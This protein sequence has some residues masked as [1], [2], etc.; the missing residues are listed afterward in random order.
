MIILGKNYHVFNNHIVIKP[1]A[2]IENSQII[3][4]DK[5]VRAEIFPN[6]GRIHTPTYHQN[7]TTGNFMI[8]ELEP[9]RTYEKNDESSHYYMVKQTRV[10]I[11]IFE[12]L[13]L[14]ESFE[15]DENK[16]VEKIRFGIPSKVETLSEIILQTTDNYLLGPFKT[17]YDSEGRILKIINNFE[18]DK[19][20]LP[21][22][23]NFRDQ[24]TIA[25]YY[26]Y[27][28][29]IQRNFTLE[30][31]E[32][33]N[34]IS[35]LDIA[36]EEYIV[37][38]A[39]RALRGQQEFGDITRRVSQGINE[40]LKHTT[41]SEEFNT[42]RLKKTVKLL[43]EI[44]PTDESNNYQKYSREL[45][46]LPSIN[47]IIEENTKKKFKLEYERFL[48]ENND[49]TEKNR[50]L[51]VKFSSLSSE[52]KIHQKQL[53]Q[54]QQ[55]IEKYNQ[56]MSSKKES[57]EK[58]ILEH[59]FQKLLINNLSSQQSHELPYMSTRESFEP[60]EGYENL[61]EIKKIFKHNLLQYEERDSQG[62]IFDYCLIA[63]KFNQPLMIAG[64]S[65]LK[66]AHI[67]QKTFAASETQTIIPDN[68][69]FNL[70]ALNDI[71]NEQKS[72]LNFTVIHNIQSSP[73]SLNLSGFFNA[74]E[75]R[76]TNNKIIFT[77]DS[78]DE[79]QFILEQL[80]KY[81]ILDIKHRAFI[82]SPFN[83]NEELK[84]GQIDSNIL[85]TYDQPVLNFQESLE[86]LL[87]EILGENYIEKEDEIE[88][89]FKN[90]YKR[91]TYINQFLGKAKKTLSYFPFL[92]KNLKED[93]YE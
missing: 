47:K 4:L 50:L 92:E 34:I 37:R 62:V 9:T 26:D 2:Q 64:E 66:L 41:F 23:D 54:V 61:D 20:I 36:K 19:Y 80:K 63:L 67:I 33:E 30:Y 56:F 22:Y 70:N 77:F 82:S 89:Y 57:M 8:Y 45:L 40:W 16:I 38:E 85:S 68:S 65:S 15:K 52:I 86:D 35:E 87:G 79:S 24:L 78:M 46:S 58:D 1:I 55:N 72:F 74:Y 32:E 71:R 88:D 51:N 5:E 93:L 84:F 3:I 44:S 7:I 18:V 17:D 29:E 90:S 28:D 12:V 81:S 11:P 39:I 69:S 75:S 76:V 83:C 13:Q 91:I 21:V 59:Y 48:K 31:P 43:E 6:N 42:K 25:N 49:I 10:N 53:K 14:D 60:T 27:F 73:I